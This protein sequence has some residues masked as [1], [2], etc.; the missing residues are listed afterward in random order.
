[1]SQDAS[2]PLP[3]LPDEVAESVFDAIF[4]VATPDEA[5]LRS[6]IARFPDHADGIAVHWRH[7]LRVRAEV[8][9]ERT[10]PSPERIGPYRI[11]SMLG[12]G[13]MGTVYLAEQE[14]PVQ[15][16]V[17]LKVIKLGMDTRAVLARFEAERQAL[18]R[19]DHTSI[20]K[21]F[22][23]GATD[24]GRPYFVMEYVQGVPITRYCDEHC[25]P[26]EER[27]AIFKQVC[28]AVQHAHTKGV[29][30]RDLT[31]NNVLVAVQDGAPL[32]KVIDFGLA[33]A[34]ER[35]AAAE[36]LFTDRGVILGTPEY[37]SPEQAGTDGLDIDTRSDVYT[38]GVL[39]YEL[40][41]GSLP[42]PTAQL[43]RAGYE[44]MCAIIREQDPERPSTKV[45]TREHDP[46][47]VARLRRTQ[48][49]ALLRRLRGD[50]DWV[51][52][53][54]LEKDRRRRYDTASELAADVQRHLED[55][56]VLAR[57]PTVRYRLGKLVRR[58][59]GR[60]VA[61]SAVLLVLV[62]GL[63]ASTHL[64]LDAVAQATEA[65]RQEGNALARKRE[66]DQLA[67]VVH[68]RRA[69][70]RAAELHPPWPEQAE[71][72]RRW[73]AD[74]DDLLAMR[75]SVEDTLRTLHER[76]VG[77]PR[78][79]PANGPSYAGFASRGDSERF[80]YEALQNQLEG[81]S[82][83]AAD[84]QAAVRQR[85]RWAEAIGALT[86]EHPDAPATWAQARDAIARADGIVASTS[87]AGR[88]IDL[89]PQMG[90]VPIGMNPDTGLWEF[91]ELRSAWDGTSDPAAI[92][93]PRYE[94][95]GDRPGHVA[96]GDD[97]GIVFVLL[98]GGEVTLGAQR[99]DPGAVNYDPAALGNE[100]PHV[101]TLAPFFM[102]RHE[103]TQGQWK[104]LT[105]KE[106][107]LYKAG[108]DVGGVPITW[109]H[110]VT[111]VDWFECERGLAQHGLV[112]PTEA[113][114]EYACRGGTSTPW[115]TGAERDSLRGATNL[116]D[117]SAKR[118][119][120]SAWAADDW[121]DF[122]DGY[123]VSA[124]VD[125]LRPNPFGLHQVHG[126][127][128]EWC[129]DPYCAYSVPGRA[130]D[131]LR[132]GPVIHRIRMTRGGASNLN[133]SR[134]RSALRMGN[135]PDIKSSFVGLRAVRCLRPAR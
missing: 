125:S 14:A 123:P 45:T 23:A 48:P 132:E 67:G 44:R 81:M 16:L 3:D 13:G 108:R 33:R 80:L 31:P 84:E 104:R 5:G 100:T 83:L 124:P 58:H 116:A 20:A 126:N 134:A 26:V 15:R 99:S 105:G 120:S 103:M 4:R 6:L 27:L 110:P 8:H 122:D 109:A 54:C 93:I 96:V 115:W 127:V 52:M 1:M 69:R 68:L 43:R 55:Q 40:L 94:A 18:A 118:V 98:P 61:V 91:Y 112:L 50:L 88:P 30:H 29:I 76:G 71:A 102:A 49:D 70:E 62:A 10:T 121:P 2:D 89:Q 74:V 38:L 75:A 87:Y 130:G 82:A 35:R 46:A 101:V 51:V 7:S 95:A 11:R 77:E 111:E 133:A 131:G 65:K 34:T 28:S 64:W 47:Q 63:V 106:Q 97:T 59:R 114:W 107:A 9:A 36:T 66:F 113:Q 22:D 135:A 32:A 57:A 24:E 37:M 73:L 79:V 41:T 117:A 39:L 129:Q 53:K 60:F 86:R 92:R 21:V 128:W 12:A 17:A 78:S 42:F 90:L 25:L 119:D 72:M 19:M 85:L 56:P